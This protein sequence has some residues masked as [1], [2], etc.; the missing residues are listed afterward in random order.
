MVQA[1]S[2]PVPQASNE[3]AAQNARQD[4]VPLPVSLLTFLPIAEE[5]HFGRAW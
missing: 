3:I 1:G 5:R 4:F 2:G